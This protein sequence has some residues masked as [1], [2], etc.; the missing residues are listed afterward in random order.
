MGSFE[1]AATG[2][3]AEE[4]LVFERPLM[5]G[6]I[7]GGGGTVVFSVDP[8]AVIDE[9]ERYDRRLGSG[10]SAGIFSS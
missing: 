1:D 5:F 9:D 7:R 8:D 10:S 3:R 6:D 2:G 4:V